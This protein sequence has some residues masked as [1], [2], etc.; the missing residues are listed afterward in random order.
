MATPGSGLRPRGK[1]GGLDGLRPPHRLAEC[2]EALAGQGPATQDLPTP[3]RRALVWQVAAQPQAAGVWR[4]VEAPR[5]TSERDQERFE[6]QTRVRSSFAVFS[7]GGGGVEVGSWK[8]AGLT[9]LGRRTL[10]RQLAS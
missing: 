1:D 4:P 7:C 5:S 9:F 6:G 3:G 8:L 10:F 2:R